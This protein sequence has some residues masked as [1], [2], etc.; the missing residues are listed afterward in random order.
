MTDFSF[1]DYLGRLLGVS[2][3]LVDKE[4]E[5]Y[6]SSTFCTDLAQKMLTCTL[7][8]LENDLFL[9]SLHRRRRLVWTSAS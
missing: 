4:S 9:H 1:S 2:N 7:L 5:G 3:E 8:A 6:F